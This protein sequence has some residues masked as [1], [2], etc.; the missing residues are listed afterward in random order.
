MLGLPVR[1]PYVARTFVEAARDTEQMLINRAGDN[2]LRF[3]PPLIFTESQADD[4]LE[5]L[6]RTVETTIALT[7]IPD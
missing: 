7:Q 3:V 4:A 5:R 2:T 1:E 6:G